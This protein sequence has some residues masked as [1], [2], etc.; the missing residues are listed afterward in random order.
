MIHSVHLLVKQSRSSADMQEVCQSI[1]LL[2]R[3]VD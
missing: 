1:P 2:T 3:G